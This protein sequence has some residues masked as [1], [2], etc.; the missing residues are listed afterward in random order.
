M[1]K[2]NLGRSNLIKLLFRHLF[3]LHPIRTQAS[4][5]SEKHLLIWYFQ[6]GIGRKDAKI[7]VPLVPAL[8]AHSVLR[9]LSTKVQPLSFLIE[10]RCEHF[11]MYFI[12]ITF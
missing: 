12:Q 8:P 6:S 10:C 3:S 4:F 1:T 2:M 5:Y 9:G 11:I 7:A